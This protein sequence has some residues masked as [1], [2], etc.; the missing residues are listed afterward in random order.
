MSGAGDPDPEL[1]ANLNPESIV[2]VARKDFRDAIRSRGLLVL[3]VVFVVFFG[4][5]AYLSADQLSTALENAAT[6]ASN[7]SQRRAAE[8]LRERLTSD[9]FLRNLA[10]VTRLFIPLTAIVVSYASVIGERESGTL[11]LLLSLP[12][13]RL[14]VLLGKLAGRS[15]VVVVPVLI[16][17]GVAAPIFPLLG[18]TFK[19]VHFAQFALLTVAI[20]VV[21]VAL[22]VGVSAAVETSR[23]AVVG[24][25]IVYALFTLMW[26]QV[27]R[28]LVQT[29]SEETDLANKAL[30]ELQ[31]ALKH[32]NPIATYETLGEA[33]YG[34]AQLQVSLF[35]PP[36][37][38]QSYTE[39]FGQLPFYLTDGALAVWLLLWVVVPLTLGYLAFEASDL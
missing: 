15:G 39:Q 18:V 11:K 33:I 34:G 27:T 38:R 13:S 6:N 9:S 25:V 7:A 32:F 29:A 28:A 10:D 5:A 20:G 8:Q 36:P 35:S 22:S 24:L 37:L 1:P 21:F 14:D 16:G 12:H 26:G 19:A 17:F 2:A 31:I 30:F 23:R 4:V 3:T